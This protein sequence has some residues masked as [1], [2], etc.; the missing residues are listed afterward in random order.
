MVRSFG[1]A[2]VVAMP[3]RHRSPRSDLVSE[4]VI[5]PQ[6]LVFDDLLSQLPSSPADAIGKGDITIFIVNFYTNNF[7]IYIHSNN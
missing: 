4:N 6:A 1:E 3:P 7:L 2:M 5:N